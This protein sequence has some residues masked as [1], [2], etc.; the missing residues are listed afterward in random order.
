MF[1]LSGLSADAVQ[2]YLSNKFT[3]GDAMNTARNTS[4]QCISD[5]MN[6]GK[7]ILDN[8]INNIRTAAQNISNGAELIS[9]CSQF[10][11]TYPSMAGLIARATCL[12]QVC[13]RID[14]EFLCPRILQNNLIS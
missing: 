13:F 2:C 10:T 1:G 6:Q 7:T 9:V 8:A 14:N 11:L 3:F 12:S 5:K 4:L